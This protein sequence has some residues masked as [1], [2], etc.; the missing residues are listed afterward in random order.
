[1]NEHLDPTNSRYNPEELDLE[2][3]LRPL[4]FDDFSGQDQ[5]LDNLKVFVEAANLRRE[6]LDHTLFHGP[7]GLGKTTLA[8]ILANELGV[9]IKITSGPVL[10]KPGD[11]AGLL[12]NL[13]DRDVLFI[14]EIHRL[15]PI[16]EEYLYSAMEDFKIDI[17]IESGP[18]ARSVQINLNPFTLV[19]A[20]T[21]SG[22]LTAPMRARFGIQSRLQYYTTELL[23][24]IIQRSAS[25][26]KMPITM[27][28]A[29]EIAGRSR[30]TPRIANALLRRVRDFAQIKGNGKI[31]IEISRYAL[32]AL[33]VDAHGLDEMDNKILNT[34]IDKFKG[35]PVG[36][37]TLATAVSE[38]SETIEEVY[39]PF[40]IQEGFI[41]RTPRGREVTEKAY[42][43]LGKI[44]NNIQGGLF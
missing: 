39:E 21:R 42:R 22:L 16:V 7:P 38:S 8:N 6:A 32:K 28:A 20:T 31:D 36:L 23:T 35:G 11:L 34:V 10:D 37:S 5:I 9:G 4:S 2:K 27:E 43:H 40:L 44:R 25:I 13:E 29:I 24:T 3:K 30:G 1:M 19:G 17:M 33:N 26:L 15:S 18:N 41:V 14:D 12:T